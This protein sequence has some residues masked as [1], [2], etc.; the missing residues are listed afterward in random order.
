M[1]ITRL[2]QEKL[3]FGALDPFVVN[4]LLLLPAAADTADSPEAEARFFSPP[5]R[6]SD[7]DVDEDWHELVEPELRRLFSD[8]LDIVR[9]D[10]A[11]LQGA[12]G[13]LPDLLVIPHTHVRGW[14]SA[15]NQARLSLTARHRFTEAEME[16][17]ALEGDARAFALLQVHFY[18]LIQGKFLQEIDSL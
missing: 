10:L 8:A 7:P 12:D 5:T 16:K 3:A 4:L 1:Y 2:D 11:P 17:P 13:A 6:G 15:L 18:G 9:Q 14:I